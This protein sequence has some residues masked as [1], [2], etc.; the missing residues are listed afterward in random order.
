MGRDYFEILGVSRDATKEEI[1]QAYR[2]LA[3]K[4]H[5]DRNPGD[6]TA[7]EKFKEVA[8]AYAVLSDDEKRAIYERY[9]EA[10]L[11]GNGDNPFADMD[12]IF[13]QFS[14]I[15]GDF[16]GF[17]RPRGRRARRGADH[18]VRVE[19]TLA[20][21]A[22][23]V[24]KT[25]HY[26]TQEVCPHC[27]GKGT[28]AGYT[29]EVC[30]HCRG[31]GQIRQSQ[32]FFTIAQT[33]PVCGGVGR[34]IRRKCEQCGGSGRVEVNRE[35]D[36]EIPAGIS[37]GDAL[38]VP[39]KGH[40]DQVGAQAGDLYVEV[41]VQDDPR[42]Q[43]QGADLFTRVDIPV[44]LAVLGGKAT[45]ST[46]YGDQQIKIPPGTQPGTLITIKHH[47]MPTVNRHGKGDLHCTINVVIPQKVS[48][49]ER[50]LYQELLKISQG[51]D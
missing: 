43:R 5:P 6:R 48:R 21:A 18:V 16:F 4:Y 41:R 46:L 37:T 13:S 23:G 15:F 14:D 39:F 34:V 45:V 1:R 32:G 7:E 47:G 31:T 25:L 19:I 10:G 51:D 40:E 33:C 49:K 20:E 35:I 9:G 27:L 36:V 8:Q 26:R 2:R 44:P 42:F 11:K 17:G 38:R 30:P 22:R 24:K 28:A 12:D 50:K 3:L 29:P